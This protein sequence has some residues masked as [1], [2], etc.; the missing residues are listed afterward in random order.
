MTFKF[1][2]DSKVLANF[3]PESLDTAQVEDIVR[4]IFSSAEVVCCFV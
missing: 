1:F 2:S 3:K 4:S